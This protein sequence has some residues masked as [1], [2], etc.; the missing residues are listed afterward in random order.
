MSVI[1][2]ISNCT[3]LNCNNYLAAHIK[4]KLYHAHLNGLKIEIIWI[5][6]H[7]GIYGNEMADRLAKPLAMEKIQVN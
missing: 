4:N 6:A 3:P 1:T 5:P 2:A 7:V